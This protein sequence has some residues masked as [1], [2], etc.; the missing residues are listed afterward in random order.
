MDRFT[1]MRRLEG[2]G[3]RPPPPPLLQGPPF[4][5][6]QLA[7]PCP[8][9]D[10]LTRMTISFDPSRLD[11]F[12]VFRDEELAELHRH[13]GANPLPTLLANPRWKEESAID[14]AHT[15]AQIE[16]NTYSRADTITLL[17]M[18]RTANTS[19]TLQRTMTQPHALSLPR[20]TSAPEWLDLPQG[21]DAAF[22]L[23]SPPGANNRSSCLCA[24]DHRST[25]A[26]AL[27]QVVT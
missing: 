23:P 2:I 5:A 18:G 10:R 21:I 26:H 24:A 25:I 8:P 1:K 17:K 22:R 4:P 15:S 7:H 6:E 16:G 13:A 19:L 12:E 9:F 14:F 11:H 3:G 20:T 27:V